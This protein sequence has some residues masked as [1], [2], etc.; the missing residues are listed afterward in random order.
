MAKRKKIGAGEIL[1][2]GLAAFVALI[3]MV[4]REVWIFM[5]VVGAVGFL[6]FLSGREKKPLPAPLPVKS[7]AEPAGKQSGGSIVC[8]FTPSKVP[9]AARVTSPVVNAVEEDFFAIPVVSKEKHSEKSEYQLPPPPETLGPERWIPAGESVEIAGMLIPG[10]LLYVGRPKLKS[11]QVADPSLIATNEPVASRGDYTE[12]QFSYWPSYST[13]SS[14]ARRAYLNWLQKGRSDPLADIGFVFLFFY[15]LERRVIIDSPENV[16]ARQEWPLIMNELQRLIEIYGDLSGSFRNYAGKLVDWMSL[17]NCSRTLYREQ[18]PDFAKSY[19]LPVYIKLA[20]GQAAVDGVAVPVDLALAWVRN[21]PAISLRT[22]AAR[23]KDEFD[24]L[25]AQY[26]RD[27]FKD[28][29][30]L[31]CNKTKLKCFYQ[32]ASSGVPINRD[33]KGVF[34]DIP[35]VT[36][37]TAPIKK[38]QALVEIVTK[39]LEPYSRYVGRQSEARYALEGLLLL[40]FTLWPESAKSKLQDLKLRISNEMVVMSFLELLSL[41]DAAS[42]FSRD[43]AVALANALEAAGI[44]IE[45]DLLS[46]A[47]SP[48]P[49]DMLV[50]FGASAGE[51]SSRTTASYQS[52]VLTLQVASAVAAADGDFSASEIAHLSEQIQT[53][54]HLTP[55]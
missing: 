28:G 54:T 45:P 51:L 9:L 50:L 49:E 32:P 13:I 3:M 55:C 27:K 42:V 26:Y 4:P 12:R 6:F 33:L 18:L 53:W 10:G 38:L 29:M 31:P 25:F 5:G 23:C 52:A 35:D 16:S 34:G 41:L 20:L 36:I 15:G 44:G 1:I 46:G 40:P 17:G 37:L 14:E 7:T 21:D 39:E 22:P 30:L 48:K 11:G 43:K 19:E 47:R 8:T 24:Q 2:F